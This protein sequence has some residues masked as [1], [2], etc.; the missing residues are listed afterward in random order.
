[1]NDLKADALDDAV[2]T[3]LRIKLDGRPGTVTGWDWDGERGFVIDV[4]LDNGTKTWVRWASYQ[5]RAEPI[6]NE[7]SVTP[8]AK[9]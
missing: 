8:C 1:M 6:A 5:M 2:S 4:D 7:Q 3:G 9:D